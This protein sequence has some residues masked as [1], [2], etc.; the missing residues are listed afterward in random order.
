[1]KKIR[2]V[3]IL[4][5]LA[6]LFVTNQMID[7]TAKV[8]DPR[9]A[10]T[11]LTQSVKKEAEVHKEESKKESVDVD[12]IKAKKQLRRGVDR[13]SDLKNS[14]ISID[15]TQMN[16]II[17]QWERRNGYTTPFHN[18][19]S[20]FIKASKESGLDPL[21][22][23]AHAAIESGWGR[24]PLARTKC[25]YFGIAAFDKNPNNA[26]HMGNT[27]EEGICAGAVW[28]ANNFY[29][30]GAYSLET[31][32]AHGYATDGNWESKIEHVW[33]QSYAMWWN[34]IN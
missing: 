17:Y 4:I 6:A 2:L 18:N 10:K 23:F 22:L 11:T 26:Y 9:E 15:K 5:S 16:H 30:K 29:K 28:I 3:L 31:M 13:Y 27:L 24:S 34:E 32:K 25:N 12:K 33:N 1:M 14:Y 21:Y 7:N 8:C 20:V 19:G